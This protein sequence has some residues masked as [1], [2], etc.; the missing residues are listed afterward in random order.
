MISFSIPSMHGDIRALW[1]QAFGDSEAFVSHYFTH[2]H[3]D[4]NML[5]CTQDDEELVAM[6]TMLPITL[7]CGVHSFSARY[8]YAVATEQSWRGLGISTSLMEHA[9]SWMR[10]N[11]DAAAILV[12]AHFSLFSFYESQGFSTVFY[13][14]EELIKSSDLPQPEGNISDLTAE[15]LFMMRNRAFEHSALFAKWDIDTLDYTIQSTKRF[16]GVALHFSCGDGEGYALATIE[17]DLCAVKELGL[18]G[19]DRQAALSLLHKRVKAQRYLLHQSAQ[20]DPD[21]MPFGMIHWLAIEA[22][23]KMPTYGEA[24]Y[25]GL[26]MD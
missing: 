13:S 9:L 1:K 7:Q 16:G 21:P 8:I 18:F 25:F 19:L 2:M 12:P 23:K 17:H 24:P 11:G 4:E 10:D 22:Q 5:V 20:G 3:R 26:V 14:S 15:Q 6:M